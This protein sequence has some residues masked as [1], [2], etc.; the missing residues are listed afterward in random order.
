MQNWNET[1]LSQYF[2]SPTI[3][4]LLNSYNDAVEASED[5]LKLYANIWDVNTAVGSGLDIWGE[6]VNVS[7]YL[8]VVAAQNTFGFD[9]A[10]LSGYEDV[11]P[12]PF[13]QAPFYSSTPVTSTYYLSD[14]VYRRLIMVKA[15]MNISNLST[16]NINKFLQYFFGTSI[17]GSPY[18]VAYVI[19]GQI[20][21]SPNYLGF[22]EAYLSGFATTGPQPFGQAAFNSFGNALSGLN[23]SITYHFDFIPNAWQLAIVENSGVFPRPAGVSIN[24]TY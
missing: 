8:Q 17:D 11:G 21:G 24:V 14:D 7:R 16:P 2:D 23:M 6:I 4:G 18:G 10:F 20:P 3:Y 5:I 19:D 13:G 12:Q 9:E 15:A 1:L 22:E